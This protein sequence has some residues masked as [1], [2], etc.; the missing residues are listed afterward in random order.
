MGAAKVEVRN[1]SWQ[2]PVALSKAGC[3]VCLIT[4]SPVISQESLPICAGLAIKAGMDSFEAL[5]AVT[6]YAAEHIGIEDRVGS[7]EVGKDADIIICSGS[8]FELSTVIEKVLIDGK[9]VNTAEE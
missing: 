8:P 4:D 7:I 2:T 3:H 9:V 1:K 5:K 6:I